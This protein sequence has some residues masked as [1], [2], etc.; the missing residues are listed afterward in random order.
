MPNLPKR[1][2]R[3]IP[4][5]T[6]NEIEKIFVCFSY[7]DFVEILNTIRKKLK[8]LFILGLTVLDFVSKL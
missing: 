1:L 7:V 8:Y 3:D 6:I 5:E 2:I 4:N